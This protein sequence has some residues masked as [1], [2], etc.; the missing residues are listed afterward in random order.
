MTFSLRNVVGVV[1]LSKKKDVPKGLLFDY[2]N[3]PGWAKYA[4]DTFIGCHIAH[5]LDFC[6]AL[7]CYFYIFLPTFDEAKEFRLGWISKVIA[8]NLAVEFILYGFWH[9]MLYASSQFAPP[10]KHK[11]FN[12]NNQYEPNGKVGYFKSSTGQLQREV[13]F[14]TIAFLISSAYQIVM[15]HLW[16]K[17]IIPVYLDFWAYP[18]WSIG[19]MIFVTYWREFHFYWAH[20]AMHPWW[21]I[22]YGL[23][24]GD[25]GAVLYRY[26]HSLHHKSYNPGPWAGLSMHPVEHIIYYSVTLTPLLVL[27]HP[28]HFLF[29]KF[30]ADIA[31]IG[32]H[33]GFADPGGD[34]DHHYMHHA[35]FDGNYGTPLVDFD[36]LFGTYLPFDKNSQKLEPP[37][38][39]KKVMA[40]LSPYIK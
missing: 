26:V 27:Q 24:E 11:K 39:P 29:C 23:R 25:I 8:F 1:N 30:H 4:Y 9:H 33:D 6:V 3:W 14:T 38:S 19:W 10:V 40:D 28:M 20:R 22:K 31:P 12:K 13:T 5:L 35:K 7:I 16:A 34:S 2:T 18:A 17:G 21:H 15:T 37:L 36:R 32:G